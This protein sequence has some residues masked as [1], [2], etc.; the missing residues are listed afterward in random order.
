MESYMKFLLI[1]LFTALPLAAQSQ[2]LRK[3]CIQAA[4]SAAVQEAENRTGLTCSGRLT[5][6]SPRRPLFHQVNTY[7]GYETLVYDVYTRLLQIPGH[8]ICRAETVI[9][10]GYNLRK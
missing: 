9:F 4:E 8:L 3:I 10:V 2:G 7:C 5:G 1:I 6:P